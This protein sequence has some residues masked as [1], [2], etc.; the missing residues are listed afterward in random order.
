MPDEDPNKG[1]LVVEGE[2]A[3][4]AEVAAES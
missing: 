1:K 4:P 3:A 2:S